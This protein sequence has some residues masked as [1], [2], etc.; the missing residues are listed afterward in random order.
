VDAPSAGGERSPVG[1]PRPLRR[2]R[3]TAV[4]AFLGA[5]L[6]GTYAHFFGCNGT[7]PI[8]SSVWTAALYGAVVGLLVGWPGRSD[9]R[10]ARTD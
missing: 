8:T 9:P 10:R 1:A 4:A 6:A 2:F 3:F 7:C 5:G